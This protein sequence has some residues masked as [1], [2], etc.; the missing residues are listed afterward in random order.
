MLKTRSL[1][2]ALPLVAALF[3]GACS[4]DD[5][6]STC[7][8][9]PD[10]ALA[11]AKAK[12]DETSG[13]KVSLTATNFPS[14]STGVNSA[15]GI[16]V[17]PAG[18]AGT[19]NAAMSAFTADVEVVATDGKVWLNIAGGGFAEED[20]ARY[21]APDPAVLM[22]TEGGAS[23]LLVK[24]TGVSGCSDERGGSDNSQVFG[25]FSGTLPGEDVSRIIPT[26]SGDSFDV[27]Y[28]IDADG[29]VNEVRMTGVFYEGTPEMTYTI[30]F[31]EYGKYSESDVTAP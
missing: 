15:E 25:K 23:D 1:L 4:G 10:D 17:H 24:T 2:L 19:V 27:S 30:N 18:F 7:D 29:Q 20:P 28:L 14:G 13:L 11:Q 26:A 31:S 5:A 16:G 8:A 6:T 3:T 21:N 9:L 12:L 22:A